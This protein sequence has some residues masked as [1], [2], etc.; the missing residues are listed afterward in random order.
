MITRQSKSGLGDGTNLYTVVYESE[1]C[2]PTS[3]EGRQEQ[4]A[5]LKTLAVT[6]ELQRTG[7]VYFTKMRMVHDGNRWVITL[8][9]VS[10]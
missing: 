10:V 6:P 4:I 3:I 1:L 8:E 9:G 7:N 5:L 2:E